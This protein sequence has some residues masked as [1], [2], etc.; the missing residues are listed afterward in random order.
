MVVGKRTGKH[1][2]ETFLKR[3]YRRF[4][5][6]LVQFTAGRKIPDINSG[7]RVFSKETILPYFDTLCNT[8]SFTTSLTLAYMMTGKFVNYIPISYEK[9]V[10]K[11]KVKL[12]KDSLRTLQFIVEAILFYNPIKI[13]L[14]FDLFLVLVALISLTIAFF[15]QLKIAYIMGIGSLLLTIVMF[16]MGLLSVQL[17]QLLTQKK[18]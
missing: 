2:N 13:F 10:G 8:F 4:L 5:K 11:T 14:V 17:K 9:R 3:V 18:N 16:G 15:T 6:F 1:L 7:L 12:F